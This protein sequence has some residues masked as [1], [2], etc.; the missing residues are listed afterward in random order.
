VR[1]IVVDD[2]PAIRD[3]VATLVDL[4]SGL[5][6]AGTAHTADAAFALVRRAAPDVAV[7]DISLPDSHGLDLL[8]TLQLER[9]SLRTI[10]FSMYD[11][12]VY[13][14]RALSTGALAYVHKS[15]PTSTLLE[16]IRT[17]ARGE[18]Y[19]TP[20]IANSLLT[21]IRRPASEAAAAS[22][23]LAQLT[24]REMAVFHLLAEGHSCEDIGQQLHLARKTVETYRRRARK[25][26]GFNSVRELLRF[27]THWSY[28]QS[29][30]PES[31]T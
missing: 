8:Q 10:V 14:R 24:D 21:T 11:G 15:E 23:G 12:E 9:P 2:H 22:G 7:V 26:L 5:S 13:A 3:A 25:K 20:A 31:S 4:S 6:M 1:V 18:V 28:A 17:V 30:S 19:L 16:A 29:R 27:A